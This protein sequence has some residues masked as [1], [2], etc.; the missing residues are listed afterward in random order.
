MLYEANHNQN[1]GTN[2]I[3]GMKEADFPYKSVPQRGYAS[4]CNSMYQ[5]WRLRG[6]KALID[7]GAYLSVGLQSATPPSGKQ[8]VKSEPL[9]TAS[10]SAVAKA[11]SV[12][13]TEVKIFIGIFFLR[14][15]E[16]ITIAL[17]EE[18]SITLLIPYQRRTTLSIKVARITEKSW[19][20]AM[21]RLAVPRRKWIDLRFLQHT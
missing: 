3:Q 4:G 15:P 11:N 13:H 2:H 6:R 18:M 7:K 1:P 14:V 5:D 19:K 20:S 12:K 9:R 21:D 10:G 8:T 16:V 17:E